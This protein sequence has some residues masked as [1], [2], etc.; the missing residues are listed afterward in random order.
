MGKL[1]R[2]SWR[3]A[4]WGLAALA[5]LW[6]GSE[7]AVAVASRGRTFDRLADVPERE[8]GVVLGTSKFV[9]PGRP[10]RHY[11]YRI[12][13]AAEL[14]RAGKV[15]RLIV[16]G[17]GVEAGYNEPRM[18]K[19]DLVERGVPADKILND[20]AGLRTY[21]SVVRA[22]DVF[23]LR[24]GIV[25]SQAAHNERAIFIGRFRGLDLIGWNARAVEFLADPRTAVRERLAR[26]KAV[27][28][29][30]R[31]PEKAAVARGNALSAVVPA[32]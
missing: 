22:K 13:A 7:I 24:D 6:G 5:L 9:G 21:D 23:H 29:V 12:E 3:L 27:A 8:F 1:I 19:A 16:S 30:L 4:K 14:F 26:V 32:R 18:M 25:I 2:N 20:A 10:N 31:P 15:R 11:R 17:N 28:D